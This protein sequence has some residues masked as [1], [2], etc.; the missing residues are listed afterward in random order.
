MD[1]ISLQGNQKLGPKIPVGNSLIN[2]G[3]PSY[4]LGSMTDLT[5]QVRGA[6]WTLDKCISV[7]EAMSSRE[8][9]ETQANMMKKIN[10]TL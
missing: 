3:S 5:L 10:V 8:I 4:L 9:Q 2:S 6:S 7:A 1:V